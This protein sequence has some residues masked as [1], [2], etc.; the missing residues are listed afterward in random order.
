V[1]KGRV[2][3]YLNCKNAE[4][5]N[6]YRIGSATGGQRG[7]LFSN[8]TAEGRHGFGFV[9]LI[10]SPSGTT[11]TCGSEGCRKLGSLGMSRASINIRLCFILTRKLL[12]RP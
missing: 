8:Y 6:G 2:Y 1:G 11:F 4:L 10:F 12:L 3:L 5:F 9:V 7:L